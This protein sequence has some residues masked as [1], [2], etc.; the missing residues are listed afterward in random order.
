MKMK[1]GLVKI[2]YIQ[3][4]DIDTEKWNGVIAESPSET[5]YP[6]S[7]YLDAVSENWS[8]FVVDDYRFVMP[9]VWK[10]K[11]GPG[12]RKPVSRSVR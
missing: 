2:A 6:Y 7:W 9:L 3:R 10:K 5:I 11:A 8:A 1:G 12:A 4:K